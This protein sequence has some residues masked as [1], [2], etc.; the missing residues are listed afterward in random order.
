MGESDTSITGW[1]ALALVAARDVG[2]PVEDAALAGAQ[3][4]IDEMSD[5]TTDSIGSL[6]A[7]SETNIEAFPHNRTEAI[8]ALGIRALIAMNELEDRK[9]LEKHGNLLLKLLPKPGFGGHVDHDYWH[10][11]TAAMYDLGGRHWATWEAA[12]RP[13]LLETQGTSGGSTG[14]WDPSGA[15]GYV[16]GRIYSTCMMLLSLSFYGQPSLSE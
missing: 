7:R 1:M 16:G 6:C 5:P 10:H 3:K 9:R 11:G 13:I 4:R 2:I 15:W 8:T 14:S 12:L